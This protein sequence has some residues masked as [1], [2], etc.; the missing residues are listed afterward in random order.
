MYKKSLLLTLSALFMLSA[1]SKPAEQE[2]VS[3]RFNHVML[4]VS[5]LEASI[6]F[7]T[8]AFDLKVT[9]RLDSL[10]ITQPD[11]SQIAADVNMAFLKFP[12]QDFVYEFSER[13]NYP[14]SALVGDHFQHLGVDVLDIESAFQRALD[15]GGK[16]MAPVRTVEGKGVAAKNAFFRG[17]DGEVVELMEMIS[18]AF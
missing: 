15:A 4:Y 2:T 14:D 12:G 18:G 8:K 6:D 3:P 10:R 13:A 11:G 16:L 5:D 7:Y 17:P 1:C 9:N